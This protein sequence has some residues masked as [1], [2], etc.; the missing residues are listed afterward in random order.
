MK[1][2]IFKFIFRALAM[3]NGHMLIYGTSL[4]SPQCVVE[5]AC[6]IKGIRMFK[7]LDT[8]ITAQ[9][10]KKKFRSITKICGLDKLK[11]AL[12]VPLEL[13]DRITEVKACLESFI[14][15]GKI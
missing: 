2:Y 6:R 14:D 9:K 11:A 10:W 1:Y 4:I 7:L 5:L 13:F 15:I 12:Y 8:D 3:E